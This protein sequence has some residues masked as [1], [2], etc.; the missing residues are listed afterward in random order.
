MAL[1]RRLRALGAAALPGS[2]YALPDGPEARESLE[3]LRSEIEGQGGRALLMSAVPVDAA[4]VAT[5]EGCARATREGLYRS[6]ERDAR[7][8]L[9]KAGARS[10]T[11]RG[12]AE[13]RLPG[14]RRRLRALATAGGESDAAAAA[15]EAAVAALERRV[16]GEGEAM[17]A[18]T[19]ERLRTEEYRGR[20]WVTRPRPGVDR[21]ASAWLIRRFIDPDARFE[22]AAEPPEPSEPSGP[23]KP[24]RASPRGRRV[25][26]DMYGVELGHH[27]GR[28][29]FEVLVERFG[30]GARPALGALGRLVRAID[31]HVPAEDVAEA[32]TLARLVAGLRATHADDHQLL[33]AGIGLIEALHAATPAIPAT[34][35]RPASRRARAAGGHIRSGSGTPSRSART[36][37]PRAK[38]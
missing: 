4:A 23:S 9:R 20:R 16:R 11:A 7:A 25:A 5:L 12:W 14:L 2:A 10:T 8:G 1:W 3:W 34:A 22:F 32:E 15:A 27:G 26:F 38:T 29:T 28:C 31:L 35:A 37:R 19:K 30:L 17:G 33:E 18:R 21:M 13:R 6:L 36:R 24:S